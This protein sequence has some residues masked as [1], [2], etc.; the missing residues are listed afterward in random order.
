[1]QPDQL[2]F[3]ALIAP[4]M[5]V[6]GAIYVLAPMLPLSRAWARTA[7]FATVWLVVG[8][9]QIWRLFDTVLP[10]HGEWYEVAWVWFCYAVELFALL[11]AFILYLTFLRTTDRHAEADAHETRLRAR[12]PE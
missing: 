6:I 2:P 9:Y 10:A 3:I 5:F 1:M 7:V 11:D 8:R 4:T 12:P